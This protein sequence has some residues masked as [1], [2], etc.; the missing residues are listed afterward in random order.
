MQIVQP[1]SRLINFN[2]AGDQV[3]FTLDTGIGLLRKIEWNA[4]ISHGSEDAQ[5]AESYKR[6]IQAV[7]MERGDWSVVEHASVTV[8]TLVDRGITHEWVRHRLFSF[9]Q[10]STRFINYVKKMPPTFIDPGLSDDASRAPNG[11]QTELSTNQIWRHAV[12]TSDS[13]YRQ[14]IERG[15]TPQIARSV[16]PN[17]LS[18]RISTT[19]NLRNWRHFFCMRTSKEAHPQM[20]QVSIPLLEEFQAK[21]P[22]L[23]DDILPLSRQIDNMRLPR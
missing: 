15:V 2:E 6:F 9:T 1:Y 16:F 4:R 19:G 5:T 7:V 12:Q 14:L 22:M 11:E 21:I 3:E 10:S 23:F 20:R 13:C 18:S 8:D 17:A